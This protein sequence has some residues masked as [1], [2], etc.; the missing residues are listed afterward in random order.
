MKSSPAAAQ[1][2][3]PPAAARARRTRAPGWT[4]WSLRVTAT[5]HL[6]GV[7]GQAA[8]AGLF[9]TG[10]VDMLLLHRDNAGFTAAMLLFQLVAAI[11]LWRPVRGPAWPARMTGGLMVAE[12][13]Q[14]FMGQERVL[15]G[16]FPL[17][18]AIFG[19]S[20]V[21]TGWAWSGLRTEEA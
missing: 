17:G 18:V 11:L 9:V 21:L 6:L 12:T 7:L 14:V 2:G 1:P 10:D 19:A 4:V 13:L 5:L 8:L 16:H 3:L 20:A 15:I